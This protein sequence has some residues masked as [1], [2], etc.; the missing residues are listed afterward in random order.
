MCSG[1]AAAIVTRSPRPAINSASVPARRSARW[2]SARWVYWTARRRSASV[3]RGRS[4]AQ[5]CFRNSG[6]AVSPAGSGIAATPGQSASTSAHSRRSSSIKTT[7]SSPTPSSPAIAV[8][9]ADFASH[10]MRHADKCSGRSG[11]SGWAA[12]VS[13]TSVS[14]FLLASESNIPA[15]RC[16]KANSCSARRPGSTTTP[17]GPS[18]PQTPRHKVLSQSSARTLNGGVRRAWTRRAIQVPSAA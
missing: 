4:K 11:M 5:T 15:S 17:D 7:L 10:P 12:I 13:N 2:R 3:T 14:L 6:M 18:S 9:L 16:A 1:E 8:R